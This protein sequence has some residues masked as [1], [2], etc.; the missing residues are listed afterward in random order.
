MESIDRIALGAILA[1][2]ITFL[3]VRCGLLATTIGLMLMDL[4]ASAILT[5]DPTDW[6]FAPTAIV[7]C[8]SI[9]LIVF[10]YRVSTASVVQRS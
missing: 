9:A 5:I 4:F 6:Y 2:T 10:G 8:F 3:V 1:S 7:V